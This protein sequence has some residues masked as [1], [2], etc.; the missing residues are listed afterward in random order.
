MS[1]D[2][3]T[4]ESPTPTPSSSQPASSYFVNVTDSEESKL[5]SFKSKNGFKSFFSPLR[6]DSIDEESS[7][8]STALLDFKHQKADNKIYICIF[9][10]KC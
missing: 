5:E 1:C 9:S 3:L 7:S 2:S 8:V 10:K 6:P 4:S